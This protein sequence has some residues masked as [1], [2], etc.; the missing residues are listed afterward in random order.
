MKRYINKIMGYLFI[1]CILIISIG[2]SQKS[3][4]IEYNP[5]KGE[6]IIDIIWDEVEITVKEAKKLGVKGLEDKSEN[7]KIKVKYPKV[8]IPKAPWT[9]E[10]ATVEFPK[11]IKFFNYKGNLIKEVKLEKG[12]PGV[13][14][15]DQVTISKNNKYLCILHTKANNKGESIVL[16]TEGNVL[17]HIKHNLYEAYPSP[18]GEYIIGA[19]NPELEGPLYIY[20]KNGSFKKIDHY[21][22]AWDFDFSENG[23]FFAVW[24]VERGGGDLLILFDKNGNEL[25]RKEIKGGMF[26]PLISILNDNL[27]SVVTLDR[28]EGKLECK[29]YVFDINGNLIEF[30]ENVDEKIYAEIGYKRYGRKLSGIKEEFY[31]KLRYEKLYDEEK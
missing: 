12:I 31:E 25:W 18:D 6:E 28:K 16:D 4:R 27:I 8:V 5:P 29:R 14:S 17:W 20:Y 2:A 21:S 10:G 22:C 3:F 15:E 1:N 19:P 24:V 30:Q 9:P 11:S 7:E 26:G 13:R 23:Y